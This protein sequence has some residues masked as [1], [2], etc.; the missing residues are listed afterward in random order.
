[1]RS[2]IQLDLNLKANPFRSRSSGAR[3]DAEVR[4]A[5]KLET[6]FGSFLRQG[7]YLRFE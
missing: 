5:P 3:A 6:R 1:M 7:K 4:Y 2:V